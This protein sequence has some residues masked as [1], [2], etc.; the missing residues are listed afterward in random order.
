VDSRRLERAER[1]AST[2]DNMAAGACHFFQEI[3][4]IIRIPE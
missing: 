1:R 4:G 2:G 3:G